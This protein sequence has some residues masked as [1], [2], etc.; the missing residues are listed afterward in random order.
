MI[1]RSFIFLLINFSALG[2]GGLFTANGTASQW[3]L[4]LIKAP[5]TPPGWAFGFAWTIIM[6]CFSIYMACAWSKTAGKKHLLVL[7]I[8]QWI[9]NV[10][11]NPVFFKFHQ[12]SLA[13][14]I[15][16]ALTV[17]V[18]YLLASYANILKSRSLLILPYFIWLMVATSLNLFI[19]LK[20]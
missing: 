5:W 3:Y 20:N 6:I 15:I 19:L 8:L 11:W 10:A 13:L 2:L 16:V 18:G 4:S 9:L 7:F 1:L 12:I 14:L 17:L